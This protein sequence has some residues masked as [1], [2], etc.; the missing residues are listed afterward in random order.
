MG[1]LIDKGNRA[2]ANWILIGVIMLLVQ[3]I[4]GGVTKAHG[5]GIINNRMERDYGCI[6]STERR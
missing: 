2:V 6:T 5:V 4:L 3:V 1:T